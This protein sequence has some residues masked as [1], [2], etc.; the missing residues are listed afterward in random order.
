M[1]TKFSLSDLL[2]TLQLKPVASVTVVCAYY[3]ATKAVIDESC[4]SKNAFEVLFTTSL[5][6]DSV[7]Q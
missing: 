4:G 7:S 1:K 5:F 6:N 3:E 2:F